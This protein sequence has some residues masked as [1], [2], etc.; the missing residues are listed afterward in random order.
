MESHISSTFFNIIRQDSGNYFISNEEKYYLRHVGDDPRPK[1]AANFERDFPGYW[2]IQIDKS[3]REK[4]FHFCMCARIVAND[5][6]NL[7]RKSACRFL[8]DIAIPS[9]IVFVIVY[10]TVILLS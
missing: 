5:V 8:R 10:T 3:C 9:K 2:N 7:S 6:H 1:D 4:K